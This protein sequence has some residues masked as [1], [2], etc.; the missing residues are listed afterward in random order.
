MDGDAQHL[1]SR[2]EAADLLGVST[3]TLHR[4]RLPHVKINRRVLYRHADLIAY[5][6]S[7]RVVPQH[8]IAVPRPLPAVLKPKMKPAA[9]GQAGGFSGWLAGERARVAKIDA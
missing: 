8:D 9:R 3:K 1:L 7:K 6:E 2:E 5:I 4:L